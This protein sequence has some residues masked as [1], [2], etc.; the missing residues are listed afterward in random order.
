MPEHRPRVAGKFLLDM[1]KAGSLI[2]LSQNF[3]LDYA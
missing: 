3:A 1:K 2:L